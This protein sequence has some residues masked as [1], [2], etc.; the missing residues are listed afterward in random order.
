MLTVDVKWLVLD[1]TLLCHDRKN[2]LANR[3]QVCRGLPQQE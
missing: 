3:S 1:F 2:P